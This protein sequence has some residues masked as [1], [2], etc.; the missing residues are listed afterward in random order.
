MIQ[1]ANYTRRLNGKDA[2]QYEDRGKGFLEAPNIEIGE[3]FGHK[4]SFPIVPLPIVDYKIT[5]ILRSLL[6]NLT[7]K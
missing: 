7:L 5:P 6:K 3:V 1:V 2:T 4:I